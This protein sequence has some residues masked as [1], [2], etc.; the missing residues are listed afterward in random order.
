VGAGL[1]A[2]LGAGSST[3]FFAVVALL[4]LVALAVPRLTRRLL[5]SPEVAV[6]LYLVLLLDRPG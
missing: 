5:A 3:F 2:A 6:P 4:G 1:G